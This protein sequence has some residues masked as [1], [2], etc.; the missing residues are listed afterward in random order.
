M[1]IAKEYDQ[2]GGIKVLLEEVAHKN[3][4]RF[5]AISRVSVTAFGSYHVFEISTTNTEYTR[6]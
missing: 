1:Q 4:F 3:K 2:N 6:K 5:I